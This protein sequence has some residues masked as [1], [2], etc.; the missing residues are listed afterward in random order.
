MPIFRGRL[1]AGNPEE[2][3]EGSELEDPIRGLA[4][5]VLPSFCA[6][7]KTSVRAKEK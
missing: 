1:G 2:R 3:D 5:S 6:D 4:A 7:H